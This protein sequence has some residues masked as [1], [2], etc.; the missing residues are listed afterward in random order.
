MHA[1]HAGRGISVGLLKR[2]CG[3]AELKLAPTKKPTGWAAPSNFAVPTTHAAHSTRL[4]TRCCMPC[5]SKPSSLHVGAAAV[6]AV[7]PPLLFC[8]VTPRG[9][10]VPKRRASVGRACITTPLPAHGCQ[11]IACVSAELWEGRAPAHAPPQPT[12]PTVGRGHFHGRAARA[13]LGEAARDRSRGVRA[14]GKGRVR[15]TAHARANQP[16]NER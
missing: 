1:A 13:Q 15:R 11:K 3:H 12:P 16:S 10:G 2:D 14:L 4:R 6:A 8:E 5:S 9:C 7:L